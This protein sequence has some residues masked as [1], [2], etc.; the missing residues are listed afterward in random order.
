MLATQA[1]TWCRAMNELY[2]LS[3]DVVNASAFLCRRSPGT[4]PKHL[5]LGVLLCA[6][7]QCFDMIYET[8]HR[9]AAGLDILLPFQLRLASNAVFFSSDGP[10]LCDKVFDISQICTALA[11]PCSSDPAKPNEYRGNI[12]I[13]LYCVFPAGTRTHTEMC[14]FQNPPP[15]LWFWCTRHFVT[16]PPPL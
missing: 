6:A 10:L 12:V 1:A 13:S 4:S 9:T 5:T 8:L 14:F 16:F 15:S 7:T 3:Y 2:D 11:A